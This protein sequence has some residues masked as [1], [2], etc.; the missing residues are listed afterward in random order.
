MATPETKA[1]AAPAGK[2]VEVPIKK[3]I[4]PGDD[5]VHTWPHLVRGEFLCSIVM[6]LLL[7]VWSLLVDAPLEEPANPARTPNP[8]KAP[9]Y[10]LGLQEMLVFFDPW[11]AGVV[12]PSFIIVGLMVIPYIDIN[13]KGNGYYCW[14]DRKWELITFILGFHILWVSLIIIGTFLRG[15]GWNWFW[16]WEKWDPHK[17]E[18]LTNVD[19]P[20]LLGVRD[21]T[22]AT[23]VGGIAGRRLLRRRRSVAFYC[24]CKWLKGA[25]FDD[26]MRRW[27]WPRFLLTGVPL[28]NMLGRGR[29]DA[30]AGTS[31][32]SSTSWCSTRRTSASTSEVRGVA[33]MFFFA[34]LLQ[35]AGFAYVGHRALPRHRRTTTCG[36]EL[37]LALTGIGFFVAGRLLERK[38]VS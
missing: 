32:T 38:G 24:M 22:T 13:P 30:R 34:K 35:A 21:E 15:P 26:F 25:D 4:G 23:I 2:R 3:A 16:F 6:T 10:F 37:Y 20:Y 19:L 7:L 9:W 11:H 5:K 27:G 1:P 31:S 14:K 28:V 36:T 8:S 29:E 33:T 18:S 12:L 17:V